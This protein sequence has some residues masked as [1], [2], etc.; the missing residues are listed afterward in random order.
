MIRNQLVVIYS[1]FTIKKKLTEDISIKVITLFK[2]VWIITY[3]YFII[4]QFL[5]ISFKGIQNFSLRD[6]IGFNQ[7]LKIMTNKRYDNEVNIKIWKV[8]MCVIPKLISEM[9]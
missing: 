3:K 8:P 9:I 4:F 7:L 1:L 2:N 6:K 5:L